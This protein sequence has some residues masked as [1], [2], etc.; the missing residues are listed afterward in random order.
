MSVW[1]EHFMLTAVSAYDQ[2]KSYSNGKLHVMRRRLSEVV[3]EDV[4]VL[5]FGS[6]ARRDASSQSDIDYLVVRR[7]GVVINE[8]KMSQIQ[9]IIADIVPIDPA[10]DGAFGGAVEYGELLTNLG[11]NDDTNTNLTRRLLLLLEGEWLANEEGFGL[12]RTSLLEKYVKATPREGQLALF[13]LNDIIRYWR[14]MT[15]D[16]MYKTTESSNPKPWAIRNIKLSFSRK[17]MYASGLFSVGKTLDKNEA[18]KVLILKELFDLPVVERM[19]HICGKENMRKVLMIYEKFLE[20][21]E[22]EK[23]RD[24]LKSIET[25]DHNNVFF[26]ELKDDS[27]TMTDELINLFN[28]TFDESHKIHRS[29][30]F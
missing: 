7:D 21:M 17:L 22:C 18:E 20:K 14:T 26:R 12:L 6:Y 11:G 13:L 5:T 15:V 4:T 16:Y 10:Y 3:P 28:V 8:E 9:N 25:S 23:N 1:K 24:I 30:L 19:E 2:A 29:V 27:H